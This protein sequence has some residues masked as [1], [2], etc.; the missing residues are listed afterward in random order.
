MW[1]PQ[2]IGPD[3]FILEADPSQRFRVLSGQDGRLRYLQN[4]YD[5]VTRY[6]NEVSD[7]STKGDPVDQFFAVS[8]SRTTIGMAVV[9][10][11]ADSDAFIEFSG[12]DDETRL[13]LR[14]ISAGRYM[15]STGEVLDLDSSPPTYANIPLHRQPAPR[16]PALMG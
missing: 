4:C 13:Q 16:P 8:G 2:G 15:S 6:L 12:F 11:S 1:P 7:H 5:G 14:Q 3:E 10:L 9:R